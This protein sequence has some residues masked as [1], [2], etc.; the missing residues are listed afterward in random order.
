MPIILS[1]TENCSVKTRTELSSLPIPSKQGN[2]KSE[3]TN[4]TVASRLP[5][6]GLEEELMTI[7]KHLPVSKTVTEPSTVH[8]ARW[9]LGLRVSVGRRVRP[10]ES[11]R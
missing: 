2:L 1:S 6:L 11:A 4:Q 9:L 7:P 10:Q 5:I 3:K 8:A